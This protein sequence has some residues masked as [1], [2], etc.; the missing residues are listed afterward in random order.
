MRKRK[1]KRLSVFASQRT[2][3][4]AA[5]RGHG[6]GSPL[7]PPAII[8]LFAQIRK[9]IKKIR[10]RCDRQTCANSDISILLVFAGQKKGPKFFL[11]KKEGFAHCARRRARSFCFLSFFLSWPSRPVAVG[12]VR[13]S[14][15][16]S[17]WTEQ[18]SCLLQCL[19]ARA[20][21]RDNAGP[22]VECANQKRGKKG[23]NKPREERKGTAHAH[24]GR[25]RERGPLGIRPFPLGF[26]SLPYQSR[27]CVRHRRHLGLLCPSRRGSPP[28]YSV[29]VS[30][31]SQSF[32]KKA[33]GSCLTRRGT[34]TLLHNG[35]RLCVPGV[36]MPPA[37]R[38][39]TVRHA[40]A[41]IQIVVSPC[42]QRRRRARG[43]S[44][45]TS[46]NRHARLGRTARAGRRRAV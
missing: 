43:R 12:L 32:K 6:G 27:M 1:G 38:D 5:S 26:F 40:T 33:L 21:G 14:R 22:L 36:C 2:I 31:L 24:T 19:R 8:N 44:V 20:H 34:P 16:M 37:S 39:G 10:M 29:P 41:S 46:S 13:H 4:R 9:N 15:H 7:F 25:K 30:S 28:V 35:T 23:S 3:C 45:R 17:F 11:K 18:D 42:R